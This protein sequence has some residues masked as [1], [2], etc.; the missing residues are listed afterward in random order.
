[1]HPLPQAPGQLSF[2]VEI[3]LAGLVPE[4]F[5][6]ALRR[7]THMDL[8]D[9]ETSVQD[10]VDHPLTHSISVNIDPA[11]AATLIQLPELLDN[12][13][14]VLPARSRPDLEPDQAVLLHTGQHR[15]SSSLSRGINP[16]V[17]RLR[18]LRLVLSGIPVPGFLTE[19]QADE[20]PLRGNG[21][22]SH[23]L[24]IP[25]GI[26]PIEPV[27]MVQHPLRGQEVRQR[28][29]VEYS[30][31]VLSDPLQAVQHLPVLYGV[32]VYS[33]GHEAGDV[34][35]VQGAYLNDV[36]FVALLVAGLVERAGGDRGIA[37]HQDPDIPASHHALYLLIDLRIHSGALI[38]DDEDK[39]MPAA[40]ADALVSGEAP[41]CAIFLDTEQRGGG[42][43]QSD[44]G[45]FQPLM[46]L[47]PEQRLHLGPGW[48]RGDHLHPAGLIQPE[49]GPPERGYAGCVGLAGSMTGGHYGPPVLIY[50]LEHLPGLTPELHLKECLREL[51]N[52][53]E[54]VG[55][56]QVWIRARCFLPA[57]APNYA[58]PGP[59][60]RY[61]GSVSPS[62]AS[63][64]S[65]RSSR[66]S[67]P[68]SWASRMRQMSTVVMILSG[69]SG[70]PSRPTIWTT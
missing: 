58:Q 38:Y 34:R 50:T 19:V 46:D 31:V 70:R 37:Q 30:G 52:V 23:D 4:L 64:A 26:L 9:L 53:M 55:H 22:T 48:A 42:L 61:R 12:V 7:D 28:V 6:A 8:I 59:L 24:G 43:G 5:V 21:K 49:D 27:R 41:H 36:P 25:L 39:A 60:S 45:V 32:R 13:A 33:T 67:R 18:V 3:A 1:M 17:H 62:S 11:Q 56:V 54:D 29:A 40:E 2:V 35:D 15:V 14:A 63:Y 16:N 57:H 66:T 10:R 51:V 47:T 44:P 65:S 20:L 68:Y 69:R